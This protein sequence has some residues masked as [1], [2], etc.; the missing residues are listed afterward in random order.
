M[1]KAVTN[2]MRSCPNCKT[3]FKNQRALGMHEYHRKCCQAVSIGNV[4]LYHGATTH[5]ASSEQLRSAR[6]S[7]ELHHHKHNDV[8]EEEALFD[9]I[10][11]EASIAS[12]AAVVLAMTNDLPPMLLSDQQRLQIAGEMQCVSHTTAQRVQADLLQI[13]DKAEAPDYLFQHINEWASKAQAHDYN[14]RP[15]I[16]SKQAVIKDLEQHLNLQA[17]RPTVSHVKLEAVHAP[18]PIV[19]FG[20]RHALTALITNSKLMQPNNMVLNSPVRNA[21]GEIVDASPWFLPFAGTA[22]QPLDEILSGSWYKDTVES[23][24]GPNTLIYPLIVYVDTT[25]IDSKGRFKLEPI[26][27]SLAIFN[28]ACRNVF[29]FWA[30]LGH[31]PQLPP[32]LDETKVKKG[33]NARNYHTMLKFLLKD[34]VEVQ[35]SPHWF[36]NFPLR[37]GNYVKHVNLRLP[38]A[39]VISDTHH[40]PQ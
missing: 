3:Q 4:L 7:T 14:F 26:S 40:H 31:V 16:V 33:V 1:P 18:M 38:V 32:K 28:R 17:C 11:D 22:D 8:H 30:T 13:L 23:Q 25:F 5:K 2:K 20:F 21:A 34:V 10:N 37:I 6:D 39:F 29:D 9:D 15:S 27:F 24:G 12:E 36:D 19:S 35:Q